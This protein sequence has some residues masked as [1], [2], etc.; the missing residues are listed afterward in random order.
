MKFYVLGFVLF[1]IF[2]ALSKGQ[3]LI[4]NGYSIR[5]A[6]QIPELAFAVISKDSIFLNVQLG[7]HHN[8]RQV[9]ASDSDRFRIGSNTKTVTSFLAMQLV[10]AGKIRWNTGL[11]TLFPELKKQSDPAFHS[12]TLLE[13]LSFRCRLIPYTYTD[14]L[15][16]IT[17]FHG[18]ES[19]QGRQFSEWA[20]RQ[21]PLPGKDSIHF[22]NLAYIVAG[23]M[24][25]KV[26]GKTYPQMVKQLGTELGISF[27]FGAPNNTDSTQTWGHD[28][29]G[30]PE[31]P[32]PNPKLNWLLPAGNL[33]LTTRDMA[34]FLQ[35][36]L[37]ALSGHSRFMTKA[38]A[39]F[40]HFGRPKVALGW[41]HNVD[42]SG[43]RFSWHHGNPGTFLSRIY[44][45]PD[46]NIAFVLQTNRQ[47][48]AAG[49][50][51]TVLLEQLKA[52]YLRQY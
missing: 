9:P 16:R 18:S 29:G 6:H 5:K 52:R 3:D 36:Q 26:A 33:N 11:F 25:E 14:S 38:E 39:E 44:V 27:G 23:M 17:D 15:P 32:Q 7:S 51:L 48:P 12:L 49:E 40:L 35:E 13:L 50:G 21:K 41:F 47:S 34:V 43:R 30:R 10:K 19:E 42:E 31:K 4:K 37:R 22:S 2:S 1:I 46:Q 45:F 24:L 8:D 20:L 28:A